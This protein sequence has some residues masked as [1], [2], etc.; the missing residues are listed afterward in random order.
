MRQIKSDAFGDGSHPTTRLCMKAV[1]VLC[2]TRRPQSVLDV[3]TGTGILARIARQHGAQFIV[4]T[5]IDPVALEAARANILLDDH[6]TDILI[7]NA[8][9]DTWGPKF[10]LVVANIL[11]QPLM[12]MAPSLK[13]AV[14]PGG[15]LLLSG[16]T[17]QQV[18]ALSLAFGPGLHATMEGWSLLQIA[19]NAD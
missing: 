8:A 14:A 10:D 4:G 18:P 5:D 17:P 2:R 11:E 15:L 12:A 7:T 16:F 3:G 6:S 19:R 9:P 1:E 13:S